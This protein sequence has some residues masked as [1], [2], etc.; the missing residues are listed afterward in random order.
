MGENDILVATLAVRKASMRYPEGMSN[1]LMI[2]SSD[3]VMSHRESEEK[4]CV[5]YTDE[6]ITMGQVWENLR[7][8]ELVHQI[9][10]TLELFCGSQC[11][12][13]VQRDRHM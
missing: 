10:R 6:I 9:H 12:K 3:V 8:L 5:R 1:V 2:E 7:G 13:D 11:P 4:V